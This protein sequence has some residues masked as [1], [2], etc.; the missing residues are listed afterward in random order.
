VGLSSGY[1]WGTHPPYST[2]AIAPFVPSDVPASEANALMVLYR[3]GGGA[4]WANKSGWLSDPVVGNWYGVTVAG[5]HV[6]S[7]QLNSNNCSGDISEFNPSSLPNLRYLYLHRNSLSGDISG[8]GIGSVLNDLRIYN[9]TFSGDVGLWV[10]ISGL[11]YFLASSNNLAGDIS[12]WNM[13][14]MLLA[15]LYNN[16]LNGAPD[17]SSNTGILRLL[18]H[19]N[20]LSQDDV[21]AVVGEIYDRRLAFTSALPAL[22]VG[23]TNAEPSGVYQDAAPPTTGKEMIYKLVNDP[24]AEGFNKWT[25]TYTA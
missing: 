19:N 21:D 7:V 18:Y 8:W 12:S 3:D 20:G 4:G 13:S 16:A 10:D 24:D 9:N 14:S 22:N 6:T 25:I 11:K 23:G 2:G 5:G 1:R 17:M 15:Y